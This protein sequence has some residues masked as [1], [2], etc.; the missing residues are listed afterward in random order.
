MA[1]QNLEDKIIRLRESKINN[2]KELAV[3]RLNGFQS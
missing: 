3:K 1:Q 2:V